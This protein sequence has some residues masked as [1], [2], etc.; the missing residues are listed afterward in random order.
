M[1]D[2]LKILKSE[3]D[4][5]RK[6]LTALEHAI[7]S[8]AGGAKKAVKRARKTMSAAARKKISIA[9]KKRWSLKKAGK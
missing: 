8:L 1:P 6:R 2:V 4:T 7:V 5:L 3:R 9:Q